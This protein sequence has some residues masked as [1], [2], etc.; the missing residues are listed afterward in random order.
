MFLSLLPVDIVRN[1]IPESLILGA[2][3][4]DCLGRVL[5]FYGSAPAAS[6]EGEV[7]T[8]YGPHIKIGKKGMILNPW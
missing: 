3:G 8:S 5:L 1:A 2:R 4:F 7:A 6:A